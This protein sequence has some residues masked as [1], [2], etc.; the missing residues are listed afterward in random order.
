MAYIKVCEVE[1]L[2][3][4]FNRTFHLNKETNVFFGGNG[5]GKTSLLNVLHSALSNDL[6]EL[7]R[8]ALRSARVVLGDTQPDSLREGNALGLYMFSSL[9]R[10][11]PPSFPHPQI[12]SRNLLRRPNSEGD[13]SRWISSDSTA[14]LKSVSSQS[15]RSFSHIFLPISRLYERRAPKSEGLFTWGSS[16]SETDFDKDFE[17]TIN[18]LWLQYTRNIGIEV[19][20]EQ[21][22]GLRQ[23]LYDFLVPESALRDFRS[24]RPVSDPHQAY[25]RLMSFL[26]QQS[27]FDWSMLD[28]RNF[29]E[30]M[31][32][33][34]LRTVL[35]DVEKVEERV[36]AITSPRAELARVLRQMIGGGKHIQVEDKD[37]KA[38]GRKEE[39]IELRDL[40]SGEKQLLRI[41]IDALLADGA[42][43]IIDEPELSLHI[44][45]QRKLLGTLRRLAPRSQ[46]IV[47][48][49]SPEI[50]A[51]ISEESIIELK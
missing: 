32:D 25:V 45:W 23:I 6:K 27:N 19:Q 49:H 28:E 38:F 48:T 22:H 36:E 41:F 44:D 43:I 30:R 15:D 42:P 47:A 18:F 39:Q 10:E 51:E 3:A 21:A 35:N 2:A 12:N 9:I 20:V 37:I 16:S 29:V 50:M 31:D 1:G 24:Y 26:V 17:E 34:R 4:Q 46:I 7:K 14:E 13:D 5:S 8:T 40:S 11:T 33:L